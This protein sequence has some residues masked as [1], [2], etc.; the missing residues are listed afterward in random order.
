MFVLLTIYI[1]T[2]AP[3]AA[4]FTLIAAFGAAFVIEA[5]YRRRTGRTFHRGTYPAAPAVLG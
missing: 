2:Q 5:V 3:A 1:V 4:S